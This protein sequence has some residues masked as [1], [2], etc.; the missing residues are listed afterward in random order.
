MLRTLDVGQYPLMGWLGR[1]KGAGA[2]DE[3]PIPQ[4]LSRTQAARQAVAEF[5]AD[6]PG[7]PGV[8]VESVEV[9]GLRAGQFSRATVPGIALRW[10]QGD[11]RFGLLM[12]IERLVQQAGGLDGVAFYLRVAVNEPHEPPPAGSRSWF[13]DLPSGPY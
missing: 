11:H 13:T 1:D 8:E 12:P 4:G 6:P 9:A 5:C 10:S 2:G 7:D 3:A